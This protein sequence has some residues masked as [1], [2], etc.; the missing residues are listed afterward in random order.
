[1][2]ENAG[3]RAMTMPIQVVVRDTHP[4]LFSGTFRVDYC[5]LD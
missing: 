5:G 3:P 2:T 4:D 1:M